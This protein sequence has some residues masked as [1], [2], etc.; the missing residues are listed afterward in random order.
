M[1]E[2]QASEAFATFTADAPWPFFIKYIDG[3]YHSVSQSFADLFHVSVE[4][5]NKSSFEDLFQAPKNSETLLEATLQR[6]KK[7]Q[8]FSYA[9]ID[10]ATRRPKIIRLYTHPGFVGQRTIRTTYV[11]ALFTPKPDAQY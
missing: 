8:L 4:A 9:I 11:T 1:P 2:Y 3:E 10:P 7:P 5:L 6:V